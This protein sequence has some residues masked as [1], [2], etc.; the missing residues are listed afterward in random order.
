M[1]RGPRT[2]IERLLFPLLF[3]LSKLFG[4]LVSM[5]LAA[6]ATGF[7]RTYRAS[8]P[9]LSVGNLSVGG[10][11]K[12][13]VVDDLV[14][15]FINVNRRVAVV[16]RGYGGK[17][18]AGTALVSD[19]RGELHDDARMYGDEPV[20]LAKRNPEAIIVVARKRREGV[21][22]AEQLGAELVVL[23]DGFQHLALERDL[24]IVLLDGRSPF[25]N[26]RLMPAGLLREP[27][28]SLDR[29][30]LVIMTR[31]DFAN[32]PELG[33][34]I[35][36]LAAGQDLSD[37]LYSLDGADISWDKIN[38]LQCVAFAGIANPEG[39]FAAL[40]AKG[41]APVAEIALSDHQ[42]YNAGVLKTIRSACDH[43]DACLTTEKDIVKLKSGDLPV[44]CYAVPL[45]IQIQPEQELNDLLQQY[46]QS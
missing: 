2:I 34:K 46:L 25:G 41:I 14:R 21:A 40:R 23:D 37:H 6:Y 32:I 33:L 31:C 36:V 5:R 12:T 7:A 22:L 26:H 38:S 3:A 1:E 16:S 43:A 13:P 19:G 11:G 9:V 27:P 28:D 18:S 29:A 42:Q 15:R 4:L 17:R 45:K 10:T 8:I 39:F 20:L 44:P 24:D 35:P 30:D